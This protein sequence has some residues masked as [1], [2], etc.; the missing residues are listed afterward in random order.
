MATANNVM[1]VS[2]QAGARAAGSS[3]RGARSMASSGQARDAKFGDALG[4]AQGNG[5]APDAPSGGADASAMDSMPNDPLAAAIAASSQQSG[6]S[7]AQSADAVEAPA[8]EGAAAI[9]AVS[10]AA[11]VS[12]KTAGLQQAA[13]A[14]LQTILPQSEEDGARS[15]SMLQMLSGQSWRQIGREESPA[16]GVP[17]EGMAV[18][19]EAPAAMEQQMPGMMQQEG[20]ENPSPMRQM[21]MPAGENIAAVEG[22][23]LPAQDG[24]RREAMFVPAQDGAARQPQQTQQ[25][26]QQPVFAATSA[27]VTGAAANDA[28]AAV[29]METPTAAST[30][31]NQN[32]LQDLIRV[33]VQR[34][35]APQAA[36]EEI[37]VPVAAS[38]AEIG[39]PT[40]ASV[41]GAQ[42]DAA[43][44]ASAPV[45]R[46]TEQVE[47]LREMMHG[48]EQDAQSQQQRQPMPQTNERMPQPFSSEAAA[49]SPMQAAGASEAAPA[50]SQA[51]SGFQQMVNTAQAA[52]TEM[53]EAPAAPRQD[54]DIPTQI[55]E[56][57]RLIRSG[58]NTEMV[59]H[60]KPE[61]LGDLTLR[62]SVGANGA[63]NASFHSDNAQVRAIIENSLVQ[64]RQELS[65]QG[66]KVDNVEVYAGLSEDGLLSGQGQQAWQQGQQGNSSRNRNLDYESYEEETADL[67]A[68]ANGGLEAA[69]GVDYRV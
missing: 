64:L 20:E 3:A 37:I 44:T 66:I 29:S 68:A 4:K 54:F 50:G 25:T 24:A 1:S 35:A 48:R 31:Q 41:P 13:L 55:V 7:E 12:A 18:P 19:D 22:E 28:A 39:A 60:L 32:P 53:P 46:P 65:N 27:S 42:Q 45:S 6:G 38:E 26:Q 56:Q 16:Q 17:I 33:D 63:V 47:P 23:E 57:A 62:V 61:H 40:A 30:A 14:Q 67:A 9:S 34:T 8:A 10:E 11:T 58:E 15:Q 43:A 21:Q 2:P 5:A 69:D 49:E 52:A 59:I 51:I 36:P